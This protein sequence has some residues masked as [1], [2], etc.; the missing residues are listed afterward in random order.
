MK[1]SI[2][3][4]KCLNDTAPQ[5]LNDITNKYKQEHRDH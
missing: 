5:Y 1:I 2:L 3:T 4:N